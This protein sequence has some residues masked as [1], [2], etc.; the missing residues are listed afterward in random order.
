M[1]CFSVPLQGFPEKA[2]KQKLA[3]AGSRVRKREAESPGKEGEGRT[4]MEVPEGFRV[5]IV[6]YAERTAAE[7]G[8]PVVHWL[9][10]G[11]LLDGMSDW[12]WRKDRIHTGGTGNPGERSKTVAV[13]DRALYLP[14][15]EYKVKPVEAL[16]AGCTWQDWLE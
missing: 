3:R 14:T 1:L 10:V 6:E 15:A 9:P 16:V 5:E 12:T 13:G 4:R 2:T 7:M 8:M 11:Y